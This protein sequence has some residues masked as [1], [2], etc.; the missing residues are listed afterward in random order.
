MGSDKRNDKELDKE[1]KKN[2]HAVPLR[3]MAYSQWAGRFTWTAIIQ[4]AIVALLT[5]MLA[6]FVATTGYPILLIQAILSTPQVGFSEITALAGL[7][8][9]LVV[10]VI[11][12]GLT[13]QFYHHF[14]IRVAKPYKGMITNGLAWTHL[15]LMNV[16]VAAASLL[17]IYAGYLGDIAISEKE[18]GGFGMTIE[19]TSQQILNM[20]IVPVST[21]LLVTVVGAAAGGAGFIINQFQRQEVRTQYR[22][23]KRI[24]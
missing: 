18:A 14:E 20:F 23:G 21:L 4:G 12:T 3:I 10:G 11:G 15:V 24:E 8:L 7:G 17:M 22:G 5:A 6:A 1:E 16:G 2:A 9:Y 13:A 19:D